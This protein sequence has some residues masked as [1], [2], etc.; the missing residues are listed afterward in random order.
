[1]RHYLETGEYLPNP[2]LVEQYQTVRTHYEE[3]LSHYGIEHGVKIA[4]KHLA[5]YSK[6]LPGSAEYR[7]RVTR[8]DGVAEVRDALAEFYVPIVDREAA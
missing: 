8:M 5:W 3:I 6:G 4:R 2:T 7:G 1:M